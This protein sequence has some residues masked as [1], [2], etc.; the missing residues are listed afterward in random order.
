MSL[1]MDTDNTFKKSEWIGPTAIVLEYI[2][3]P[4][5]YLPVAQMLEFL[6]PLQNATPATTNQ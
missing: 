6:L 3:L 1:P 5:P 4:S 2:L